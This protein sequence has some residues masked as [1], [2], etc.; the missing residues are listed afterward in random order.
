MGTWGRRLAAAVEVPVEVD[1]NRRLLGAGR[2]GRAGAHADDGDS[3]RSGGQERGSLMRLG[4]DGESRAAG[5]TTG[6]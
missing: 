1:S 2:P 3:C 4:R 6:L 5:D